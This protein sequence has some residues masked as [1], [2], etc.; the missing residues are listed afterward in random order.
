M[1][2]LEQKLGGANTVAILGHIRPDGDC[3]G[4]CLGLYNYIRKYDPQ[5]EVKVYIEEK[6]ER[7]QILLKSVL[8]KLRWIFVL[9]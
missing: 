4:S 1:N 3:M 7:F 2:I 8:T 6:P 9:L 5:I